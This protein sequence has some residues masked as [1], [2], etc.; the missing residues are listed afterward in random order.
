M[1]A[2]KGHFVRCPCQA[3]AL[4]GPGIYKGYG[5]RMSRCSV[6]VVAVMVG[7]IVQ[8]VSGVFI[9]LHKIINR[10]I[11]ELFARSRLDGP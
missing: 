3:Q 8:C 4:V 10:C 9:S 1:T 2:F 11:L 5:K 7:D 6:F